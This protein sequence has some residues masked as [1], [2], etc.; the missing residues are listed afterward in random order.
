MRK[1]PALFTA[2][3]LTSAFLSG[4]VSLYQDTDSTGSGGSSTTPLS[5]WY[6]STRTW[7]V[8]L[9]NGNIAGT[10]FVALFTYT[11]SSTCECSVTMNGNDTNGT[12]VVS[13]CYNPWGSSGIAGTTCDYF[14]TNG[15][16]S[17]VNN[18]TTLNLCNAT[19]TCVTY[20]N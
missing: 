7:S 17:Y 4:C 10:S 20:E 8:N 11:D 1:V 3:I 18:Q 6:N 19:G 12:Y 15:L 2:A 9:S 13:G 16:G 14:D 5:T